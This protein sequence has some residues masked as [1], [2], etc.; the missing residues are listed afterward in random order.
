MVSPRTF[1]PRARSGKR[2]VLWSGLAIAWVLP[3]AGCQVEYAGMTL[4]SG[5]YMY[6]DVQYFP[7]GPDFPWANTQAAT[8][9]ARMQAMGMDVGPLTPQGGPAGPPPPAAGTLSP[10]QNIPGQPTNVNVMQPEPVVPPG[11]ALPGGPVPAD[12]EPAGAVPPPN[13]PG[14]PVPPPAGNEKEAGGAM[15]LPK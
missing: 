3:T 13:P 4:P 10:M 8:Q 11:G 2:L 7:P 9:R 1:A 12:A 5:K 15:D 14:A 6:D